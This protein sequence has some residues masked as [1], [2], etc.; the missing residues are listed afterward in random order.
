LRND[1]EEAERFN[2]SYRAAKAR[3]EMDT[4]AQ[5]LA[6]AAGLGRRDQ[7][8]SSKAERARSAVRKRIKEAI[9]R[10]REVI[11]RSA[12]TCPRESSQGTSALT[13]RTPNVPSLGSSD[14]SPAVV[15]LKSHSVTRNVTPL[16]VKVR[17]TINNF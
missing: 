10:I 9:N 14:F 11:L 6:V 17:V 3:G 12:A 7:R 4:I 1:L 16:S 8:S 2:D 13:I 15:T 5:Q